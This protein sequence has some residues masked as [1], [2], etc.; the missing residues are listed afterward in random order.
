[1]KQKCISV[2]S[3]PE[4]R[5]AL[6]GVE[7][8]FAHTWEN[9]YAMRLTTGL[10]TYLYC[11]EAGDLRIVCPLSERR[12]GHHVDIV[13]PYGFSGFVGNGACSWFSD[14]WTKYAQ[15]KGYVCGYIGLNPLF[16]H[17]TYFGEKE[18][19]RYN[20]IYVLDLTLSHGELFAN[21]SMNRKR[22]LKDWDKILPN[23]VLDESVLTDFLL[24]N[25]QE[26]F[27]ERAASMAYSFSEDT[28]SFLVGLDNVFVVGVRDAGRVEAVTVFAHTPYVGDFLFNVSTPEGRHHSVALLWYGVHYLKARHVPLLNLGGGIRKDDGVAKFKQRF[29]GQRLSLGCLKQIYEPE[30]YEQLCRQVNA[31]HTD[32]T[33]YFPAYRSP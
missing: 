4:W 2:D 12:F 24:A 6:R 22:Q 16:E 8:A 17:P 13:T 33:G 14:H 30:V 31:D 11:L 27:R 29:G 32:M 26:F 19:I 21:L 20:E 3:A 23:I 15:E 28:M 9:C 18:I 7:H 1:M 25:Y 5:L 10:S